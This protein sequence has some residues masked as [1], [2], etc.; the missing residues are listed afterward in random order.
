MIKIYVFTVERYFI[1]FRYEGTK[2]N[3]ILYYFIFYGFDTNRF[4]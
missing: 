2:N 4:L 1:Q 3:N